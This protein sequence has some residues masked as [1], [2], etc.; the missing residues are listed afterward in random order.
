[1]FS[2]SLSLHCIPAVVFFGVHPV[3]LVFDASAVTLYP[4]SGQ[5]LVWVGR[6][7]IPR[8]PRRCRLKRVLLLPLDGV[9]DQV[10]MS[11]SA[12]LVPDVATLLWT[13][14]WRL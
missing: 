14:I 10:L 11:L 6:V 5:L 8:R 4:M 13:A 1:M 3:S 12:L 7:G 2:V 9:D